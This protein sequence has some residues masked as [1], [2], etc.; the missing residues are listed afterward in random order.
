MNIN[1]GSFI[2]KTTVAIAQRFYRQVWDAV[3]KGPAIIRPE[4]CGN[5]EP[6]NRI[7]KIDIDHVLAEDFIFSNGRVCLG[8]V[9]SPTFPHYNFYSVTILLTIRNTERAVADDV[10]DWLGTVLEPSIRYMATLTHDLFRNHLEFHQ[11]LNAGLCEIDLPQA[12]QFS[13]LF[14]RYE[15]KPNNNMHTDQK[16]APHH[17]ADPDE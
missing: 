7:S 6:L 16:S 15:E 1:L 10:F 11:M 3:V 12:R 14:D 9:N 8:M 5:Y 13:E 4:R 17:S 2:E